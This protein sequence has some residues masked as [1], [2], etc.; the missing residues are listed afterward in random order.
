ML[1][2]TSCAENLAHL[3]ELLKCTTLPHP[4]PSPWVFLLHPSQDVTFAFI[5]L[6]VRL[7]SLS[8]STFVQWKVQTL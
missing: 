5:T 1:S 2:Y 6:T 4:T 8:E 3:L 7:G